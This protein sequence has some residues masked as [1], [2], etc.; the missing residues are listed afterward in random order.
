MWKVRVGQVGIAHIFAVPFFIINCIG[1]SYFSFTYNLCSNYDAFGNPRFV[2]SLIPYGFPRMQS[3]TFNEASNWGFASYDNFMRAFVT[4]F[5]IVTLEGWTDIM[6]RVCDAW[7]PIPAIIVFVSLILLGGIIALNIVLAVISGSL[8]KIENKLA[9]E[10]EEEEEGG[11][12]VS[13]VVIKEQKDSF[14]RRKSD[15]IL[16]ASKKLFPRNSAAYRKLKVVVMSRLYQRSILATILLN[17]IVL[18]CDHYGISPVF[19]MVLDAGNFVTTII[20]FVDM[21]LC[22]I[23]YGIDTYWR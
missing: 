7:S 10:E 15:E 16:L 6:A 23:V 22:N 18:S 21:L 13:S 12:E 11:G 1:T 3:G 14:F 8:E 2:D 9:K 4:T 17:T 5:Q 20:F 19:Q